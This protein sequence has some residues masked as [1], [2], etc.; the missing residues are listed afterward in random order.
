MAL[1]WHDAN[2]LLDSNSEVNESVWKFGRNFIVNTGNY[3]RLPI[4][5]E[6]ISQENAVRVPLPTINQESL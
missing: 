3:N 1:V 5:G 6:G 4:T 2:E